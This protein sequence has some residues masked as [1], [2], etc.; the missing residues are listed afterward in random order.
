MF[1]LLEFP[2]SISSNLFL[3]LDR[4]NNT[5]LIIILNPIP[6]SSINFPEFNAVFIFTFQSLNIDLL[7]AIFLALSLNM[8]KK[9]S[10]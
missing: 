4:L 10:A 6:H 8:S 5:I 1:S 3:H 7:S 2:I 9:T